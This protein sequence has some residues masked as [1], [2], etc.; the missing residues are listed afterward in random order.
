M[1]SLFSQDY[2]NSEH[3]IIDGGSTDGTV[4]YIFSLKG[5]VTR[6][7]SEADRG[8]YDAINK[9]ISMATGDI[10]GLLHADDLYDSECVLSSVVAAFDRTGADAVYGDLVYVNRNDPQKIIRYWKSGTFTAAN[11][12]LGWMPPHPALFVRRE[13][14]ENARLPDGRYFD[15]DLKIAADYDFM[16]RLLGPMKITVAYLPKVLV[17]MRV[18][19][20]SNRSISNIFL[21]SKEDLVAMRRNEIGGIGTLLAKNFRKV[22]QFFNKHP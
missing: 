4:D 20:V 8:V 16:I 12:K 3:I 5:S 17:K 11:L 9:G 10:I 1:S 15:I 18:G 14:Y 22:P 2:A 21:K 13:V 19:G 7:V 6:F